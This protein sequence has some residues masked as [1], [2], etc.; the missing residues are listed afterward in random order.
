MNKNTN[1]KDQT[2]GE[3]PRKDQTSRSLK[4]RIAD[5]EGLKESIGRHICELGTILR[6]RRIVI[7]RRLTDG[8]LHALRV[9]V[10]DL[11]AL[12]SVI[13]KQA[14]ALKEFARHLERRKTNRRT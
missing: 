14:E 12:Q 2:V 10:A 9:Q 7:A 6:Q 1:R 4:Q 3:N 8:E 5:L 11:K 13:T